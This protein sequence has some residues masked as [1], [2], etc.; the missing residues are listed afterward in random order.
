MASSAGLAQQ[1]SVLHDRWR[2]HACPH[3]ERAHRF[4]FV[5]NWTLRRMRAAVRKGADSPKT[6]QERGLLGR[7]HAE[8]DASLNRFGSPVP[9]NLNLMNAD[10]LSWL[11]LS[12]CQRGRWPLSWNAALIPLPCLGTAAIHTAII[13]QHTAL[14]STRLYDAVGVGADFFSCSGVV[15]SF[16]CC[17]MCC[18]S[19]CC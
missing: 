12:R 7:S 6:P 13:R 4:F 10:F 18:P 2:D 17:Y 19:R 8:A 5:E 15:L 14:L 11:F 1:D 3:C 9:Q 16:Y